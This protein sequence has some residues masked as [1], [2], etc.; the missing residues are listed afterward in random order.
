VV[1]FEPIRV[2]GER[3]RGRIEFREHQLDGGQLECAGMGNRGDSRASVVGSFEGAVTDRLESATSSVGSLES[4]SM[5]S[6]ENARQFKFFFPK[7]RGA[8][9]ARRKV[10]GECKALVC[11]W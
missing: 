1:N 4:T 8:E 9:L 3:S 6:L 5:G 7:A 10:F 11:D 2:L